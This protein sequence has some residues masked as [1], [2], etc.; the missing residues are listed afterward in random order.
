MSNVF[1][2]ASSQKSRMSNSAKPMIKM[3]N[4]PIACRTSRVACRTSQIVQ[5]VVEMGCAKSENRRAIPFHFAGVQ[6]RADT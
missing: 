5:A 6:E 2:V 1:R 4:S 3:I